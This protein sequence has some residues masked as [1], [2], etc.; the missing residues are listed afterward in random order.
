MNI[1]GVTDWEWSCFFLSVFLLSF[2]SFI[3]GCI[4]S[5]KFYK[6]HNGFRSLLIGKYIS[7]VIEE[8]VQ[9]WSLDKAVYELYKKYELYNKYEKQTA[10][11]K[12]IT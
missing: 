10:F 3:S 8:S 11:L 12:H 4:F 9:K 5:C 1:A 2:V 7:I 6:I